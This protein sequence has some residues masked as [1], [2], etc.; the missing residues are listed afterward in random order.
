MGEKSSPPIGG[1]KSLKGLKIGSESWFIRLM[2]G[3]LLRG[4]IQ[5]IIIP[6]NITQNN[7][8]RLINKTEKNDQTIIVVVLAVNAFEA[9]TREK[10][11][12]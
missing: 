4:A 6:A 9:A 7:N 10:A 2:A 5:L 3:C 8:L 1:K 11:R 12:Y